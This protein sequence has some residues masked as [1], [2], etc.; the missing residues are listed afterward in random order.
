MLSAK[1][2]NYNLK[3]YKYLD[4]D[5]ISDVATQKSTLGYVFFIAKGPI[6]QKS[7][8]QKAVTLSSTEVEYYALTN[9]TKEA[10]QYQ[11]FLDKIKYI[12]TNVHLVTIYKDNTRALALAENPEHHR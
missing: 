9:T 2:T 3:Y 5:Y 4:S 11:A 12:K 6:S 1:E 7:S 10:K 8:K